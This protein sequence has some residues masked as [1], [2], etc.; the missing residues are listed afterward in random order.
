M[1][2]R[3]YL[4][5]ILITLC[6]VSFSVAQDNSLLKEVTSKAFTA[7]HP[8]D[9]RSM[10][11]GTHYTFLSEDGKR[12]ERYA[13]DS[14]KLEDV[15]LDLD[16]IP[17]CPIEKMAGYEFSDNEARL[18]IHTEKT[19]IYRRSF[20]T[21]YYVYDIKH[22][23]FQALST[24]P[25]KQQL[26]H[27]SPNGR[28]VAFA[29]NNNL[30]LKKLDF[31]SEIQI[32][33]DGLKNH[34]INGTADWVY[35]E[36]FERTRYF[37]WSPDSKLLAYVKFDESDIPLYRFQWT[38][39]S[40][41]TFTNYKYPMPGQANSKVSVHVFD[42]QNNTTRKM[43]CGEGN[44]LYFPLLQWSNDV[45]ELVVLRL[46]IDQNVADLMNVNP[47]SG[48]SHKL[49]HEASK[50][51][52]DYANFKNLQF[53]DDNSFVCASSR[54]GY[55]HL[56]LFRASGRL[57]RQLTKGNWDVTENYGY[58]PK[59][60]TVYFQ[61][62]VK[63]PMEREVYK[64]D[65]KRRMTCYDETPGTH[66]AIF[67]KGYKYAIMSFNNITTPPIYSVVNAHNKTVRVIEDNQALAQKVDSLNLPDKKFFSFT[68]PEDVV[69][70][71]WMVKPNDFD[72][73]KSYPLVM[74]QYSGPS[75][76]QV[77]NHF[78]VDWEYVLAQK[79]YIV[80]CI[81]PRGTGAR[82]R[83]FAT[84]TYTKLG[85]LET[86]DQ[87]S[88]AHYL[89]QKAFINKDRICIWGWS[90]GGFMVL[91]C[92]TQNDDNT[93]KAGIAVAPVT[94]WKLYDSSY[95]ERY[96]LRPQENPKGYDAAN[97]MSRAAN[98]K[99][100]L[101]LCHGTVDDNVHIQHSY[102]FIEKLIDANIPFDMQIYPNKQHSILG[103]ST[104]LHL[105]SRFLRFLDQNL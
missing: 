88:A 38:T 78:R 31:H 82:G 32:T 22:K 94:D 33:K 61:A 60:K 69:L 46:N 42:V 91:N 73:T 4:A 63:N 98:L 77:L 36:E 37:E 12:I 57:S 47:R 62:A 34:I 17:N 5:L 14:G 75:S 2:Y 19:P 39:D 29:R 54:D 15:I 104:R 56:Y 43:D 66:A 81:D 49:M 97:L 79:G 90:Y 84:L 45:D 95:T 35:E 8:A 64:S 71:G 92:L 3:K 6:C 1:T 85:Q 23:D 102:L 72:S 20:T 101:L 41:P 10:N 103:N 7:K 13:Y 52:V 53:L 93:F 96:M 105:Y 80:A 26:A 11:D 99:G 40:Y 89:G 67:S 16:L 30:F 76:Q 100:N 59:T 50:V 24:K 58:D 83:D 51:Y 55:R 25:G 74:V 28:V 9:L 70:N 86:E 27:F 18:L 21:T 48:V 87:F 44:T 68:T 65:A